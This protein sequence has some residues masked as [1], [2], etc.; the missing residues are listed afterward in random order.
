MKSKTILNLFLKSISKFES[1]IFFKSNNTN[2]TYGSFNTYVNKYKYI[3]KQY[4]LQKNSNII[5]IGN[6]SPDWFASC[7][8]CYQLGL[9]FIPI[10]QNQHYDIINYIINET[11]PSL[12]ISNKNISSS[13]NINKINKLNISNIDFST[14]SSYENID[15]SPNESDCNIILYTSGTTGLSKGVMLTQNNLY[16]NIE[17]IDRLIGSDYITNTDSYVSFLP[18]SHI[19]GLNCELH[20]GM[21]KGAAIFINDS[22]ENLSTNI[23]KQ[24]P[25]II[26]TVP[27]LLYSIH[28][29]IMENKMFKLLLSKP[30]LPITKTFI[31]K[32]IF[33]SNLRFLNVGGASISTDLLNFYSKLGIQIYQGYGLSETSPMISLN[34]YNMNRLGSVGKILDCNDVK[35]VENEIQVKGSNIFSGYY[36]NIFETDLVFTENEYFKTGD[37]GYIDADGYLYITG[38]IK[39]LYKLTNGKYINPSYIENILLECEHIDQIYIYGDSKPYN[40]ALV[41]TDLDEYEIY[42]EIEKFSNRLKKY[43]IPQ[44][45]IKVSPFT[46]EEKLLTPKMS[47]IRKNIYDKYKKFINNLYLQ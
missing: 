13:P 2:I 14:I 19:Y 37:T 12:I 43:E 30:L 40:I 20:Y 34:S 6:N 27:K 4:N 44:K 17:S 18:W 22:V 8:A 26:C 31:K 24:N 23:V 39:E 47:M 7:L 25:T 5:F 1:N 29:K 15:Y 46:F 35:I 9:R 16:S 10:Y 41:V 45:I 42:D 3:L 38:R 21:S 32:K 33:G 11:E 36:K 28:D